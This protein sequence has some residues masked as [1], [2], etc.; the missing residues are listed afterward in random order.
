[1]KRYD[2]AISHL[3]ASLD[4]LKSLQDPI[5]KEVFGDQVL[6]ILSLLKQ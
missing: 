6:Y 4:H 2:E 3:Q 1:M 5:H